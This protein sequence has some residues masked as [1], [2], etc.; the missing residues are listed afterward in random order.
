MIPA[1]CA[2][3]FY[4]I[5]HAPTR[6]QWASMRIEDDPALRLSPC[7]A[8]AGWYADTPTTWRSAFRASDRDQSF[9]PP[10]AEGA[11][12]GV[13]DEEI[14]DA[15]IA[16]FRDA[17]TGAVHQLQQGAVAPRERLVNLRARRATDRSP[18][19]TRCRAACD[20]ASD[21]PAGRSDR[22]L[23]ALRRQETGTTS[24]RPRYCDESSPRSNRDP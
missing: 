15:E 17:Q 22:A 9:L 12:E 7:R 6:E 1:C 11:D 16:E 24:S 21:S 18:P 20:P 2:R 5:P 23:P 8:P 4:R 13:G 10:L 14:G 3:F 19:A